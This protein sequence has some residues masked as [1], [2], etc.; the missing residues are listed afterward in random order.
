MFKY[1]LFYVQAL[2]VIIDKDSNEK[3][4]GKNIF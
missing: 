3:H 2:L 1:E 4:V